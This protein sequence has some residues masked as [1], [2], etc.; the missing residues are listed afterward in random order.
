MPNLLFDNNWLDCTTHQV[1][2][3]RKGDTYTAGLKP[4][5]R[6]GERSAASASMLQNARAFS[7]AQSRGVFCFCKRRQDRQ[8]IGGDVDLP[9]WQMAGRNRCVWGG[10]RSPS[11]LAACWVCYFGS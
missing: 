9:K 8:V 10:A 6:Q 7:Q 5:A 3:H 4:A 1:I 2:G 11:A